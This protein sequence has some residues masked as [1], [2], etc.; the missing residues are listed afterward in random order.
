MNPKTCHKTQ[1]IIRDLA[2]RHID[3]SIPYLQQSP[4]QIDFF[5]REA[6]LDA[7]LSHLMAY[8]DG[9]AVEVFLRIAYQRPKTMRDF[10]TMFSELQITEHIRP[11][12]GQSNAYSIN[13]ATPFE[14]VQHDRLC[15][16]S[17][18]ACSDDQTT[19]WQSEDAQHGRV[20]PDQATQVNTVQDGGASD[21]VSYLSLLSALLASMPGLH[22]LHAVITE[23]GLSTDD[24]L[25]HFFRMTSRGR[26]RFIAQA[27]T[28][29]S[30]LFERAAIMEILEE[31]R[32]NIVGSL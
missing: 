21:T 8:Q 5:K 23:A 22:R 20:C 7:E 2:L 27:L 26:E 9:W 12:Q 16:M 32:N 10:Q 24:Q 31:L 4:S 25:Q 18:T 6:L 15:Q 30:T 1:R 28:G 17:F 3:F 14:G 29:T 11:C 13:M 19:R